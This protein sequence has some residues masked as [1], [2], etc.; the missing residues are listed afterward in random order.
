MS[1][2][3][4]S[5]RTGR[6]NLGCPFQPVEKLAM[7]RHE[8]QR[9]GP[10]AAEIKACD[11]TYSPLL[12]FF[13]SSPFLYVPESQQ[14][15]ALPLNSVQVQSASHT[16]ELTFSGADRRLPVSRPGTAS[17]PGAPAPLAAATQRPLGSE[18]V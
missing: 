7:F 13:L 9:Q 3:H 18:H 10:G 5:S 2:L 15:C 12:L 4:E 16:A 6:Q 11:G 8:E 14:V 17:K 1:V